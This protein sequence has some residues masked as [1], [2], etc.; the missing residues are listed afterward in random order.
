MHYPKAINPVIGHLCFDGQHPQ[1]V[2]I[3]YLVR[4][5]HPTLDKNR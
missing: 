4:E 5:T 3:D 2:D 1:Q